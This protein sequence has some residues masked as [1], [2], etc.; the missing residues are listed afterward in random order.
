MYAATQVLAPVAAHKSGSRTRAESFSASTNLRTSIFFALHPHLVG[1]LFRGRARVTNFFGDALGL[2]EEQQIVRAA[3]LGVGSAHV[4]AA[5]GMGSYH[6][7]G[8]LAIEVEVA[9]VELLACAIQLFAGAGVD[10][11]GQ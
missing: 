7:A 4:E 9:D 3:G 5:K 8:A 6:G 2:R 11:C 10:C 1:L